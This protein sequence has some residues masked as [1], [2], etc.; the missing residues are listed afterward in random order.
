MKKQ[1]TFDCFESLGRKMGIALK[2]MIK[3][4]RRNFEIN[5]IDLTAEQFF[6]LNI[7]DEHDNIILQDIADML[8][9]DKS[10]IARL[11][12]V[13]EKKHFV[14][15]VTSEEDKRKKLLLL[16]K[17]GIETLD[18]ASAI[19]EQT[20]KKLL[21]N[22]QEDQLEIFEDVLAKITSQTQEH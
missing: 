7:V 22:I 6:M 11:I 13:L 12:D 17:P 2:A 9:R 5:D 21:Q 20:E 8:E 1:E 14:T 18:D 4:I 10:A 16:T 15:R 3:E 19:A